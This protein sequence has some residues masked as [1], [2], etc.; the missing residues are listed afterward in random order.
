MQFC[1]KILQ[2]ENIQLTVGRFL[3]NY[4]ESDSK[5]SLKKCNKLR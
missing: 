4:Y 2:I 3:L 1:S 5:T